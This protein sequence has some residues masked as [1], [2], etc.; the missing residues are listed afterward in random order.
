MNFLPDRGR[1]VDFFDD[2]LA[3]ANI[4]KD[5]NGQKR[6]E[7]ALFIGNGYNYFTGLPAVVSLLG[8][9]HVHYTR[10]RI[11]PGHTC[12]GLHRYR[13]LLEAPIDRKSVV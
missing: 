9:S 13:Y 2:Q 3:G 7:H 12:I 5:L 10:H 6:I 1:L 8:R 4:P 11:L